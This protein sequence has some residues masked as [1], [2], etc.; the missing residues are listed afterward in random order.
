MKQIWHEAKLRGRGYANASS[1]L[2]YARKSV[3]IKAGS[4]AVR[5]AGG[6]VEQLKQAV[7]NTKKSEEV[8]DLT[9]DLVI[10]G[11]GA[12]G[13]AAAVSAADVRINGHWVSARSLP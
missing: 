1:I 6:D 12:A 8:I 11:A 10:V 7:N 13:M 9:P 5:Q 2:E 3:G 4:D